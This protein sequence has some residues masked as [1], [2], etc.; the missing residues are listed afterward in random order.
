[1]QIHTSVKTTWPFESFILRRYAYYNQQLG[2]WQKT[3]QL[4]DWDK[5]SFEVN[6]DKI[7]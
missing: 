6:F 3:N 1:M 2:V 5:V 7:I 4:L